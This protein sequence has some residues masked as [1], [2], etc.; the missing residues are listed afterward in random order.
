M[1]VVEDGEVLWLY[2][3]RSVPQACIEEWFNVQVGGGGGVVVVVVVV[4]V[5][6]VVAVVV[7]VVVVVAA[8]IV[9]VA[10]LVVSLLQHRL[11]HTD[12]LTPTHSHRLTHY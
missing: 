3:G 5:A 12:S 6:V 8:V 11:T 9:K 4:V 7:V 10:V 2:I 1:Y